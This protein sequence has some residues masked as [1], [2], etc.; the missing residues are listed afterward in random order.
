MFGYDITVKQ[1]IGYLIL[2]YI[3]FDTI[4]FLFNGYKNTGPSGCA[5]SDWISGPFIL[6]SYK[7]PAICS[8]NVDSGVGNTIGK[9]RDYSLKD[10]SIYQ[11]QYL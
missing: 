10:N 8:E 5:T 2:A 4:L 6:N 9:W 11:N 3:A 7:K 1:V